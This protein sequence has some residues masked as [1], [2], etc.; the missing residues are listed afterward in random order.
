MAKGVLAQAVLVKVE[1]ILL[2][3]VVVL[4]HRGE[5]LER[6]VLAAA[7]LVAPAGFVLEPRTLH[8]EQVGRLV[9]VARE[10]RHG[11]LRCLVLP[12]AEHALDAV[13]I[14]VSIRLVHLANLVGDV[15][16]ADDVARV[17][18]ERSLGEV[19][20][21]HPGL[22]A[23]DGAVDRAQRALH[24]SHLV[25]VVRQESSRVA[26]ALRDVRL[27]LV[28]TR[29]LAGRLEGRHDFRERLAHHGRLR[30][31]GVERLEVPEQRRDTLP[32]RTDDVFSN[33]RSERVAG[34]EIERQTSHGVRLWVLHGQRVVRG[35]EL[36]D[37]AVHA[38]D[39][40]ELPVVP[41]VL[42]IFG[43]ERAERRLRLRAAA[44]GRVQPG[45]LFQDADDVHELIAVLVEDR[46]RLL[47][48]AGFLQ[49]HGLEEVHLG[50]LVFREVRLRSPL[51]GAKVLVLL[52]DGDGGAVLALEKLGDGQ[53]HPVLPRPG[54]V[55]QDD[56]AGL[57]EV[58]EVADLN[59]QAGEVPQDLR[60][61][62]VQLERHAVTLD[63]L[64]VVAIGAVHQAVHVPT[65]VRLHVVSHPELNELVRLLHPVHVAQDE[66]LHRERL[67]VVGKLLQHEVGGLEPLLVLLG[68]VASHHVVELL[69]LLAGQ[70]ARAVVRLLA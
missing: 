11:L 55:L 51:L 52:D 3:V 23:G 6:P 34:E 31:I 25:I 10:Q 19:T 53:T 2:H 35:L 16:R 58:G 9:T 44:E 32:D 26:Q 13:R 12:R 28:G 22:G 36:G 39:G 8:V 48:R 38:E 56:P 5:V 62:L 49:D 41:V 20:L 65:N 50:N 66:P 21:Q 60:V 70:R 17:L 7:A 42:G 37:V 63:G 27:G 67:A 64:P 45:S 57:G 54:S 43:D 40:L 4:T 24:V 47:V 29:K 61:A 1:L 59:L 15:H 18:Q 68:L 46:E 30:P 14:Q 69:L 33:R